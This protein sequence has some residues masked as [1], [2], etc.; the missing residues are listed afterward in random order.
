LEILKTRPTKDSMSKSI[1]YSDKYTDDYYEYRHV[2]LPKEIAKRLPK[3]MR[4]LSETE[5]RTLGVQ[6]SLGWAHYEV[7]APEPHVLLFRRL[8]GTDPRTGKSN[9]SSSTTNSSSSSS[10]STTSTS[11]TSAPMQISTTSSTTVNNNSKTTTAT[12]T[13]ASATTVSNN[14]PKKR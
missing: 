8:L 2:I 12:T 13:T 10:S 11:L 9:P 3:P 1:A 6:Q 4:I 5:W 14:V 7:H